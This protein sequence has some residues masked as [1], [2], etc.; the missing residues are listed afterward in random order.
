[1]LHGESVNLRLIEESDLPVIYDHACQVDNRGDYFPI[2][3]RARSELNRQFAEHGFWSDETG[4][5]VI[6]DSGGAIVGTISRFR[7]HPN[8]DAIEVS[9]IIYD[10][11]ARNRGFATQALSLFVELLFRSMCVDRIELNIA[12]ENEASVR[13]AR[14]N[15]FTTE[16]VRR[17]IWYSPA[18][19]RRLDAYHLSLLRDEWPLTPDS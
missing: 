1:M 5:M 13:V 8:T 2:A 18:L 15:R 7:P 3:I 10:E 17:R 12:T 14:K 9:Y 16:G 19:S 4:T 6:A 11:N